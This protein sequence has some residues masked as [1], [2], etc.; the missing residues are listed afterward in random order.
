MPNRLGLLSIPSVFLP[1]DKLATTIIL[2]ITVDNMEYPLTGI[3][4]RST[5]TQI[6]SA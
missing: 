1:R 2:D 6:V 5:L 4:P 3:A